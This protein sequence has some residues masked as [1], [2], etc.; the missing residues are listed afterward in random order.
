MIYIVFF[1]NFLETNA[2]T[3]SSRQHAILLKAKV[4]VA[5]VD[6]LKKKSIFVRRSSPL[7]AIRE[8]ADL[9]SRLQ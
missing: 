4:G 3:T 9:V 5:N 6:F 1:F 7:D 2:T 8:N